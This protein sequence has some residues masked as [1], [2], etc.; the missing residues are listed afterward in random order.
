MG[1]KLYRHDG[2]RT[3][4]ILMEHD[5]RSEIG[6]VSEGWHQEQI[7]VWSLMDNRN[8]RLALPQTDIG[9]IIES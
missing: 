4:E 5:L 9:A 1:L 8:N 2:G 7:A 6:A 3:C